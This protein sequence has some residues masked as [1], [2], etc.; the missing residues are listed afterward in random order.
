M[1]SYFVKFPFSDILFSLMVGLGITVV[2]CSHTEITLSHLCGGILITMW[3]LFLGIQSSRSA[4]QI[5]VESTL[6]C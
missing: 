3:T 2:W 1:L 6:T 5:T 4:V